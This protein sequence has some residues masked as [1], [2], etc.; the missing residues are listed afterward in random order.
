MNS[1]PYVIEKTANGE[2]TYDIYSRLL[3]D[4]I[5][6]LSGVVRSENCSAIAASLLFLDAQSNDPIQFW[7]NSPGGEITSGLMV[8]D[9]FRYIKSPVHT[10]CTGMAAS[11]GS[12]LLSHGTKGFR[13]ALPNSRIMIHQASSGMK[14]NVQDMEIS[15]NETKT[16]NDNLIKMLA[17]NCGTTVTKMKAAMNRDNY[18]SAEQ[19]LKFGLIDEIITRP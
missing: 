9:L 16:L 7:I 2:R 14:G 6:F 5:I 4:R 3:K 8:A 11:M 17:E 10:I 12:F 1:I 19:A 18:M 13:K 15:L